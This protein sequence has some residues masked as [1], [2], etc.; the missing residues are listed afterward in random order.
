M[1]ISYI[2]DLSSSINKIYPKITNIN[3]FMENFNRN[4]NELDLKKI[5]NELT[6]IK[7]ILDINNI[8]TKGLNQNKDTLLDS[9][10]EKLD[11]LKNISED[12]AQI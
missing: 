7:K 3:E 6:E 4:I 1:D 10:D 5:D 2:V 8:S 12:D 11:Y 9:I